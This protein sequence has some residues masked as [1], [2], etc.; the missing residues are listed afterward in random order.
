MYMIY[1][2]RAWELNNYSVVFQFYSIASKCELIS[3]TQKA[4]T[5]LSYCYTLMALNGSLPKISLE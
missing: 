2:E 3:K 1:L 5:A 4:L